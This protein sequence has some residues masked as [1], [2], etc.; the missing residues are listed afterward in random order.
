MSLH[1]IRAKIESVDGVKQITRAMQM[2]ATSKMRK[3]EERMAT[4]R[5]YSNAM[6]KI[7]GH[8]A[9]AKPEYRAP[10]MRER[11]IE[12]VGYIIVSTDRGLCGG[13]NTNSFREGVRHMAKWHKKNIPIDICTIGNKAAA[14]FKNTQCA[15]LAETSQLG[16]D[17]RV[18][19]LIGVVQVMLDHYTNG[20]IDRLFLLY[21]RHVTTM[22]QE[23]VIR[24][25]LPIMAGKEKLPSHHWDYLYE[26]EAREVVDAVLERYVESQVYQAVI[27]NLACEQAARMVAMHSATDNAEDL[28]AELQLE[29]NKGRQA[30]ITQEL[31]EIVAGSQAV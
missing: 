11:K 7:I 28:I 19:D 17:P 9:Q 14:F 30:K 13:L 5:H 12:K 18:A 4:S 22:S 10:F 23:P 21:N 26:P 8:L 2:V 6:R 1:E 25:L 31:S 24:Q 16:D 29:Y 3:A 20:D 15:F 27:E